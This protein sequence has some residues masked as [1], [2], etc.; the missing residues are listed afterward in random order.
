MDL[1]A[2]CVGQIRKFP[3][4]RK[5]FLFAVLLQYVAACNGCPL[6]L[7]VAQLHVYGTAAARTI[8]HLCVSFWADL[9]HLAAPRFYVHPPVQNEGNRQQL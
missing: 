3:S 2:S 9:H 6:N 7:D 5:V 4:R 8:G 1:N